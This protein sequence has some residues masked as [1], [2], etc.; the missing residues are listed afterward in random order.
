[1]INKKNS[2]INLELASVLEPLFHLCESDSGE[3]LIR[4]LAPLTEFNALKSELTR[5][6][7]MMLLQSD[8]TLVFEFSISEH[9]WEYSSITGAALGAEEL[10]SVNQVLHSFFE[11]KSCFFGK[12]RAVYPA[13]SKDVLSIDAPAELYDRLQTV[14]DEDGQIRD[15]ASQDLFRVRKSIRKKRESIRSKMGGVLKEFKAKGYCDEQALPTVYH[16]RS[17]LPIIAG[18]KRSIPGLIHGESNTGQIVYFEPA[19]IVEDNNEMT[20]LSFE[21]NKVI[22]ELLSELTS[23]VSEKE[24]ILRQ[25]QGLLS[26]MDIRKAK[27]LFSIKIGADV[28]QINDNGILD[29][30]EGKNTQLILNGIDPVPLNLSLGKGHDWLIISGPNAG[31]K[32]VTLKTIG[33]LAL[34]VQ[35]GIPV[36]CSPKSSFCL[37]D[38]IFVEIGDTQSVD[39]ALSTYSGHLSHLKLILENATDR[40]LVLLDEL[41]SGTSPEYGGVIGVTLLNQVFNKGGVGCVTSHFNEL[42]FYGEDEQRIIQGSMAYDLAGM[43]PLFKLNIGL[44]GQSYAL[45]L[46]QRIGFDESIIKKVRE[47]INPDTLRY[48]ELIKELNEKNDSLSDQLIQAK[49][50]RVNLE[51]Q[52]ADYDEVKGRQEDLIEQRLERFKDEEL[53]KLKETEK[54]LK[55]ILEDSRNEKKEELIRANLRD[56]SERGKNIVANKRVVTKKQPPQLQ[57]LQGEV[58]EGDHVIVQ[59]SGFKGIVSMIKGKTATVNNGQM[60]MKVKIVDLLLSREAGVKS[61]SPKRKTV[62]VIRKT[63]DFS[64]SLDIRGVRG[65]EVQSKLERFLDDAFVANADSIRIVH[66]KGGG[67]LRDLVVRYLKGE[68]QVTKVEHESVDKGGDG[69]TIAY[70]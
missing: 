44:S 27:A 69:V 66:G 64:K 18:V 23:L 43:K 62:D 59:S 54:G 1:M 41:G 29:I 4:E 38:N 47:E 53:H 12:G 9:I 24:T 61:T 15:S 56:V 28:P 65:E 25:V 58:S 32:T 3:S 35:M 37:F 34:M 50:K 8:K 46:M 17:V 10:F 67:V 30:K 68:S 42:K 16:E 6:K 2:A 39:D 33:Q 40:S 7:E 63:A 36:P 49:K 31:G 52:I 20:A 55:K 70:L 51:S 5:T 22:L 60:Q 13:L 57:S 26:W 19:A 45:E 21:E 11:L 48:D 14:F